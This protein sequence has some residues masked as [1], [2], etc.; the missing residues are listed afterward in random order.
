MNP[1]IALCLIGRLPGIQPKILPRDHIARRD[2]MGKQLI[3]VER[4][5]NKAIGR[6]VIGAIF[7][8]CGGSDLYLAAV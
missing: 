7:G 5:R 8:D 6:F 2:L 4:P 1:L 3:P